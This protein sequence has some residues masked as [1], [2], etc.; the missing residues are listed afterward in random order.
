MVMESWRRFSTA[1]PFFLHVFGM[2]VENRRH[3]FSVT[4]FLKM[5]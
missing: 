3:F 2:A 5:L 1:K 4:Q